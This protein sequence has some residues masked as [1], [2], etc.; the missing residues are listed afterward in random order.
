MKW[1]LIILVLLTSCCDR[2]CGK[3]VWKQYIVQEKKINSEMQGLVPEKYPFV[4]S[5]YVDSL[6]RMNETQP[7]TLDY[8][9]MRDSR[10]RRLLWAKR[11]YIKGQLD[12]RL[13]ECYCMYNKEVERMARESR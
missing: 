5:S 1:W 10:E 4:L 8:R 13:D 11:R 2:E 12:I 7:Y 9:S 3:E 6:D